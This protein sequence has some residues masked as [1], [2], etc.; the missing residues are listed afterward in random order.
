MA[1]ISAYLAADSSPDASEDAL[2]IID[3]GKGKENNRKIIFPQ[4][5]IIFSNRPVI[6]L[7]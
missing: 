1:L 5:F 7:C 2:A 6:C 3:I 4:Y